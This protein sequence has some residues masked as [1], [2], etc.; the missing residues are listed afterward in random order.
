MEYIWLINLVSRDNRSRVGASKMEEEQAG[1]IGFK[2]RCV[3]G[4]EMVAKWHVI[5]ERAIIGGEYRPARFWNIRRSNGYVYVYTYRFGQGI[6]ESRVGGGEYR[7]SFN[8][9]SLGR[10]VLGAMVFDGTVRHC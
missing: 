3:A 1:N 6:G 7:E 10:I 5:L 9:P 4:R 2:S 8:G